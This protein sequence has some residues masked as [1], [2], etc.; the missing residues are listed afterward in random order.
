VSTT[1]QQTREDESTSG[2][3]KRKRKIKI[4][5]FHRLLRRLRRRE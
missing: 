5:M 3:R 2:Q 1:S 4:P